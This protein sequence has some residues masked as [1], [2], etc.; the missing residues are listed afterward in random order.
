MK[1]STQVE[2]FNKL[3]DFLEKRFKTSID[4][5]EIEDVS[6]YSYRNI[7]RIFLALQHE[8]IGQF[9]KRRKLEK[10]AEYLKFSD[11]EISDIALEIGYNDV[12]A[13][14]KAFK[15]YF[16]CT[17]SRFRNSYT[18][19]QKITNQILEESNKKNES[20]LKFEIETLPTLQMLYL[21]YKGTYENVKGIEK[22]WKQLLKYADKRK[23]LTDKTIVLGEVLDDDEITE[24]INCRYNAGI[25]LTEA[26]KI[27]VEGMFKVKEVA[28][29]KYAKFIHK[30]SHESCFETYNTIYAHWI[31]EVQLEFADAP[32]LEFYLNDEENTSQEEL[33]T[34]IYIPVI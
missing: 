28:S 21:Q 32:T 23:L 22:T 16:R 24:S 1:N 18:L 15:K 20:L 25:I 31:Y 30:G 27:E 26:Q 5:H 11:N 19:Q 3:L 34:E 7:N 6:F 9:L 12:A 29:Q 13:F 33:I 14:S 8:T 2:R 10:A 17:P 4:I